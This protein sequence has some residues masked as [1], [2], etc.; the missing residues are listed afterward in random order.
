MHGKLA[1][2]G[3]YGSLSINVPHQHIK[4]KRN[5][6]PVLKHNILFN[7]NSLLAN[8]NKS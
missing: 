1:T 5:R 7:N 3:F 4:S 6:S 8:I 2:V